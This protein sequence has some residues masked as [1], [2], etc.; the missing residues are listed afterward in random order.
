MA[1]RNATPA[2][3]VAPQ[4]PVATTTPTVPVEINKSEK[5]RE[6]FAANPEGTATQAQKAMAALGIVVGSGHCQQI[7]NKLSGGSTSASARVDVNMI[8][9]AA[10]FIKSQEGDVE[11]AIAAIDSVGEFISKCGS[12]AKA[13][14]ALEAYQA[15]A[16]ALS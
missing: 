1:K 16:A 8:K 4:A 15:M 3:P 11:T 13:K 7:K 6:W 5:I 12:P 2:A 14:A 10:E 9:V